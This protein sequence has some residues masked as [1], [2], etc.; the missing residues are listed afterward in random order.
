MGDARRRGRGCECT[1]PC[2]CRVQAI[3][4]A[5]KD[6]PVGDVPENREKSPVFKYFKV[7]DIIIIFFLEGFWC[8]TEGCLT[9]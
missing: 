9:L 5:K 8:L 6:G 2:S 4:T 7:L 1:V 3:K